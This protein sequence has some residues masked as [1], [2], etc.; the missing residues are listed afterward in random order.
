MNQIEADDIYKKA[1]EEYTD[2]NNLS[3][4]I[5][6]AK[7]PYII[8]KHCC[9]KYLNTVHNFTLRQIQETEQKICGHKFHHTSVLHSIQIGESLYDNMKLYKK[10]MDKLVITFWFY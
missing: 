6:T 3:Y 2:K 5:K 4:M 9:R 10:T 8:I 1:F 7:N